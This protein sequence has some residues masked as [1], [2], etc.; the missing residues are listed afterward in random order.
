VAEGANHLPRV[1]RVEV[2]TDLDRRL[3]VDERPE[4]PRGHGARIPGDDEGARVL[5]LQP[6]LIARDLEGGGRDQVREGSGAEDEAAC[7]GRQ[8][9]AVLGGSATNRDEGHQWLHSAR[10]AACTT[11]LM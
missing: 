5:G 3:E 2:H 4:P 10:G 6:D 7:P 9:P 8:T 11:R 1:Q